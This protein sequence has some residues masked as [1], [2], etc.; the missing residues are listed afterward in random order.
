MHPW[1]DWAETWAHYMHMVDTLET[2]KS[3]GLAVRIPGKQTD[4]ARVSTDQLAFSEF[5]SLSLGWQAVTVALNSVSRSM[6]VKDL[7]P[8][9]LSA[10]A[11]SKLRFVHELIQQSSTSQ[12]R[13][14][15][16]PASLQR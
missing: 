5:E 9:V 12:R 1:E 6:G 4:S 2:A 7:Y 15:T 16:E 11:Q 8:F 10:S 13:T 3:H 14:P